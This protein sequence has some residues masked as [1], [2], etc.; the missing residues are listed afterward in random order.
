MYTIFI[1]R[2]WFLSSFSIRTLQ[3]TL[4][5]GLTLSAGD[6]LCHSVRSINQ[7]PHQRVS[8]SMTAFIA[9]G[10]FRDISWRNQSNLCEILVDNSKIVFSGSKNSSPARLPGSHA[11]LP[12]SPISPQQPTQIHLWPN[13]FNSASRALFG[14]MIAR[15]QKPLQW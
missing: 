9:L 10:V 11:D 12:S 14:E 2:S 6:F 4:R 8:E 7:S 5:S 1:A 13:R 15:G 3:T